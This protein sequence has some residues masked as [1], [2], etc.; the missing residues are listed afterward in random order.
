MNEGKNDSQ[1][2]SE[3]LPP[4]VLTGIA[5]LYTLSTTQNENE[6]ESEADR[7]MIE[8]FIKTLAEVALSVASRKQGEAT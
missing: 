3:N 8:N 4:N 2:N 7:I 5:L 1:L 6:K